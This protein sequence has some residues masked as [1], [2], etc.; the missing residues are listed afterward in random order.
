[1][2]LQP[3]WRLFL[4][5]LNQRKLPLGTGKR[6]NQTKQKGMLRNSL[7]TFTNNTYES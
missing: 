2:R 4:S 1:M 6:F 3:N 7:L 5:T